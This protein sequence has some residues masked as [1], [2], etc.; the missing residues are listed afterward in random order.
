MATRT[1]QLA[2]PQTY[3]TIAW[4]WMR[5][6]GLLLIPLA[7][8]HVA[9]QDVIVGVHAID[10]NYV[11]Y[12]WSFIG[13]RIY[14][15]ALLAFAFAHGVNGLRQVLVDYVRGEQNRR[16]LSWALLVFWLVLSIIGAIAIIGGVRA[17]LG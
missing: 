9:L 12:R 13:W 4:T 10:L 14:D 6:S 3:D 15:F 17:E 5:Y 7:W 8:I 16:L 11:Q 2:V 1:E